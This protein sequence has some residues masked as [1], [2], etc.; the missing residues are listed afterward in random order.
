VTTG[1]H[2]REFLKNCCTLG[3]VGMA[4]QLTR[5]GM[6]TAHAQTSSS[7]KA[8]VCI[9]LFGGNDANNTIVPVDSRYSLYSGMRGPVALPL[10]SLLMAA[11]PAGGAASTTSP[12]P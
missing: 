8:L 7:Y 6:V 2:R 9:F 4:S 1:R 3:A 5:L 12:W 11:A 10:D